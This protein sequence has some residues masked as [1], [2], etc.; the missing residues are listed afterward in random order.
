[1][2]AES[3]QGRRRPV[4][5]GYLRSRGVYCVCGEAQC[6]LQTASLGRGIVVEGQGDVVQLGDR[7]DQAEAEAAAGGA[8]AGV[9]ANEALQHPLA[10][11]G[12]DAGAAVGHCEV[13]SVVD[14]SEAHAR[15]EE[16]TSELQSLMRI[17]YA[18]FC[19]KKK[20]NNNMN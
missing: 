1:M 17:S 4:T 16:H 10:I 18:V 8:T 20:T 6:H 7:C 11:L 5:R 19:L 14:P 13:R 15:S 3:V 2:T 9:E 12:R